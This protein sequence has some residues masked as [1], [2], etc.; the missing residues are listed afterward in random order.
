MSN[1]TLINISSTLKF[2]F[3]DVSIN[4]NLCLSANSFPWIK[5]TCL[6][7]SISDLF[8]TI[9]IFIP[10]Q[11]YLNNIIIL[12]TLQ[13]YATILLTYQNLLYLLYHMIV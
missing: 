10:S 6:F 12:I 8:P 13:F 11:A 2:D 1:D 5:E 9:I 4:L 3:A 7:S